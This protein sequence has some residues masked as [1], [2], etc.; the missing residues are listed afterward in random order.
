MTLDEL[1]KIILSAGHVGIITHTNPDGDALGSSFGLKYALEK[2]GIHATVILECPMPTTFQFMD[3][4]YRLAQENAY[5]LVIALDC[6]DKERTGICKP[7]FE[8]APQ[9]MVIDHHRTTPPYGH[10]NYIQPAACATG[11]IVFHLIE[12]MNIQLDEKIASALYIAITTDTGNFSYANTTADTFLVAARLAQTGIHIAYIRR[13]VFDV[14]SLERLRMQAEAVLGTRLACNGR[15]AIMELSRALMDKY[16]TTE[17]DA[18][19]LVSYGRNIA[20]VEA[21][22]LLKQRNEKEIK[23]S[24]R[25]NDFVDVSEIAASFGGGGHI[26]AAGCTLH[27]TLSQAAQSMIVAFERVL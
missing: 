15:L 22:V 10:F 16:D 26:R 6:A 24:L 2:I 21:A 23:V 25:S 8:A 14:A 18:E 9:N 11:E 13:M 19:G 7:I 4:E 3:W 17:E 12:Q 27:T 5:D 20:G 1:S